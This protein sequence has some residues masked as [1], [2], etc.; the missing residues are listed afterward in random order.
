MTKSILF[1]G[2]FYT[3]LASLFWGIPQPLFFDQI[4]YIPSVEVAMHRGLW[5]FVLLFILLLC[6]NELNEFTALFNSLRTIILLSI[7]AILIAVNWTGFIYSVSMEKV[8]DASLGYFLTPMITILLGFFFLNEKLN[9][10][11][12]IS[13]LLMFIACF[14]LF[15]SLGAFPLIAVLIGS[16]W[17]IYGLIRKQINVSSAT[18]LL[19]ESGFITVFALPYIIYLSLLNIGSISLSLNFSS[20]MLI[21]TGIV[22]IFPLFFF[23]LGL[24]YIPLGLAGVLFYIA[25][26]FHFITSVFILG[27]SIEFEKILAFFLIWIGV[28]IFIYDTIQ[29]N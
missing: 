22:T 19:Y 8:Q 28:G 25:P 2:I 5:S 24:K 7:T 13:V 12:I 4:K 18:G 10:N 3:C 6:L 11:K 20:I 21:L 29:R 26:S 9:F 23:N 16:T 15:L 17:A 1:K 14:L 27:E